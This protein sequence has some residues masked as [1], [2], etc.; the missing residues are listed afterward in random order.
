MCKGYTGE[1]VYTQIYHSQSS[2][3]YYAIY[4]ILPQENLCHFTKLLIC[5]AINSH[6]S[7]KP[8]TEIMYFLFALN[9]YKPAAIGFGLNLF[10]FYLFISS[11]FFFLFILQPQ[12]G[13]I[14]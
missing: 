9:L 5:E 10:L 3:Y 14:S 6:K 7:S 8:L 4:V 12:K 1:N 13:V 2:K 11:S